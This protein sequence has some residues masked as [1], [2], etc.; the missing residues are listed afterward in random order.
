MGGSGLLGIDSIA[1]LMLERTPAGRQTAWCGDWDENSEENSGRGKLFWD[2]GPRVTSLFHHLPTPQNSTGHRTQKLSQVPITPGITVTAL[3]ASRDTR[4]IGLLVQFYWG[5]F[6]SLY[7]RWLFCN[8]FYS[9]NK[10]LTTDMT[11]SFVK[12]TMFLV[13][14]QGATPERLFMQTT[15]VCCCN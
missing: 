2:K 7:Y 1:E 8:V 3:K 4:R 14:L 9:N 6:L 5:G 11:G 13:N 10:W 15:R 12:Q